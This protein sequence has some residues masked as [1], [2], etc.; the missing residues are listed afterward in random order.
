M[1]KS[2]ELCEPFGRARKTTG[3]TL[4]VAFARARFQ[5]SRGW[6]QFV[7]DH[8]ACFRE[9]ANIAEFNWPK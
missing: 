4:A 7:N 9:V 3:G 2:R 1:M 5:E 8:N 6:F